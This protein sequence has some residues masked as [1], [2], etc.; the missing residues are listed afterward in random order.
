MDGYEATNLLHRLSDDDVAIMRIRLSVEHAAMFHYEFHHELYDS[1]KEAETRAGKNFGYHYELFS[2]NYKTREVR[3][4]RE[5]LTGQPTKYIQVQNSPNR[6]CLEIKLDGKGNPAEFFL[7]GKFNE[8]LTTT[9]KEFHEHYSRYRAWMDADVRVEEPRYVDGAGTVARFNAPCG[10]VVDAAGNLSVV[11]NRNRV[12]RKVTPKGV[13][14]TF[15]GNAAEMCGTVDGTGNAARFNEPSG[16]AIDQAGNLYVTDD[17]DK[18]IRKVTPEG[19][20]TTLAGCAGEKGSTDGTGSAARFRRPGDL[21]V[22]STGNVFVT[23]RSDCTIRKMTP[24]GEVTTFAGSAGNQGHADGAGASARFT[25]PAGIAMDRTGN[26]F[27]ADWGSHTIRKITPA[28]VVTTWAGRAG[29]KGSLDGPCHLA[30]FCWPAGL[31]VDL[32]GNLY[33]TE[34]GNCT[35]RK[36]TPNGVVTTLAGTAG[37]YGSVDGT[38]NGARFNSPT[39]VAVDKSGNVFVADEDDCTIRKISPAGVVT[40]LAG[41]SALILP[42]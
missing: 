11:D 10:V 13:V 33:L 21:V 42:Y 27:V 39:S 40:T 12:L 4:E 31:A 9:Y 25:A 1:I 20:V 29:E 24:A 36:I 34:L 16:I 2:R 30:R 6:D 26:L 35:V 23:D 8:Y 17:Y 3:L 22:D 41:K 5:P 18:V 28:R 15:V 38:G 14:T 32:A 37:E 7:N 19:V